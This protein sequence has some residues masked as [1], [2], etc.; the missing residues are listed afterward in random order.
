VVGKGFTLLTITNAQLAGE[1]EELGV[2]FLRSD[3]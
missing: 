1:L 3:N 2:Y